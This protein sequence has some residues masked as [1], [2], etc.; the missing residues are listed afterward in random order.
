MENTRKA[1]SPA[2]KQDST[3]SAHTPRKWQV[4]ESDIIKKAEDA[5]WN[6]ICDAFPEATHGDL[7]PERTI[8]FSNAVEDAVNEWIN[9]N[10]PH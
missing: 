7:S 6:V 9:N 10:V 5:F 3:S 8:S 4:V 1:K 2:V